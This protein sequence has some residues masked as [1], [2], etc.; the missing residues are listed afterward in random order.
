[1]SSLGKKRNGSNSA[2]LRDATLRRPEDECS[3]EEEANFDVSDDQYKE[4]DPRTCEERFKRS[5]KQRRCQALE[6]LHGCIERLASKQWR[7]AG[8]AGDEDASGALKLPR[9]LRAPWLESS[10]WT[11]LELCAVEGKGQGLRA[12]KDLKAGTT[13]LVSRPI[14]AIFE[15]DDGDESGDDDTSDSDSGSGGGGSGSGRKLQEDDDDDDDE[16]EDPFVIDRATAKL[17]IKVCEALEARYGEECVGGEVG[18]EGALTALEMVQSLHPRSASELSSP[19]SKGV[20]SW[21]CREEGNKRKPASSAASSSASAASASAAGASAGGGLSAEL[22]R[23]L[24]SVAVAL[25]KK[26]A[27]ASEEG[28]DQDQ[29][30]AEAGTEDVDF[31]DLAVRL[32]EVVRSNALALSTGSELLS[33]PDPSRNGLCSLSGLGLYHSPSYFNHSCRP[34]V[35]RHFLADVAV[36]R[37]N[38][39]VA[40][41][42]E[43]C[44]SYLEHEVLG[45]PLS[46]RQMCMDAQRKHIMLQDHDNGDGGEGE[47]NGNGNGK[48]FGSHND[49]DE[50]ED[51]DDDDYEGT[52]KEED[53]DEDG[54]GDDGEESSSVDDDDDDDDDEDDSK[55]GNNSTESDSSGSSGS[56]G[57]GGDRATS[58]SKKKKNKG[59]ALVPTATRLVV[60]LELQSELMRLPPRL[61]LEQI[62]E[63]SSMSNGGGGRQL[64]KE[65]DEGGGDDEE[66]GGCPRLLRVDKKELALLKAVSW[67]E[68]KDPNRALGYWVEC[69]QFAQECCPPHDESIAVY[70]VQAAVCAAA[71]G[72]RD[73][74]AHQ[75]LGHALKAHAV[76]FGGDA[77]WMAIRYQKELLGFA[78]APGGLDLSAAGRAASDRVFFPEAS[79]RVWGM[80]AAGT[81]DFRQFD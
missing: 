63:I 76:A 36:F 60:G 78:V 45:E 13:L 57:G 14:V 35:A 49:E 10:G 73:G 8:Y 6:K 25:R 55:G 81:A 23:A 18:L 54:D 39:R 74:Q 50:D 47:G 33:H 32:P 67:C 53:E 61:R 37:T 9:H 58:E 27:G 51:E 70:A 44:L 40:K 75:L 68:L 5:K 71:V 41:G 29:G 52:D 26:K 34:N 80:L 64:D 65:E 21:R 15:S 56:G 4:I 20:Q 2:A 77:H 31:E 3:E 16:E 79:A 17:T 69:L 24:A 19:P 48:G 12:A 42:E 72:G 11:L 28:P 62:D 22:W 38:Q 66:E 43:L 30:D 7:G 1:M 46:V 59:V